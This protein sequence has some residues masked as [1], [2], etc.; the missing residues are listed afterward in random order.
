[1]LD[2]VFSAAPIMRESAPV[3]NDNYATLR[4]EQDKDMYLENDSQ[5]LDEHYNKYLQYVKDTY[6]I[7]LN[8][9]EDAE[10]EP[11]LSA[12]PVYEST[13]YAQQN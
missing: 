5:E 13:E 11:I 9:N 10:S 1:V 3:V 4:L 2:G 8:A 6:N 7:D 12:S